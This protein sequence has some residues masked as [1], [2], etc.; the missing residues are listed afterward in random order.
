MPPG[1]IAPKLARFCCPDGMSRSSAIRWGEALRRELEAGRAPPQTRAARE[2]RA[3][4][5]AE[6]KEAEQRAAREAVTVASW[7]EE[8]LSDCEARRV[9]AT[10]I[11]LRRI[12]L[13]YLL[14]VAGDRRVADV[15]VLDLQ[16]LRRALSKLAPSSA[17]RYVKSA[18]TCLR[19]A[20]AA[21]LRGPL[22]A[23]EPIRGGAEDETPESFTLTELARLVAAAAVVSDRHLAVVLLGVDAGL[24]IGEIAGLRVEDIER[25]V[26]VVRRTIVRINRA[27][28]EH[29]PK[30]GRVRRIPATPRLLEVLQ[31][32]ADASPDGWLVRAQDGRP[33]GAHH[34]REAFKTVV[35]RAGMSPTNA[36]RLRHSFATHALE[37]G[38]TLEEVRRL[39]GHHSI[40]QTSRYLHSTEQSARAAIDRLAARHA[41]AG[42]CDR[43]V[44]AGEPRRPRLVTA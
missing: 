1:Q 42:E 28:A 40:Q 8:Y 39:L 17:Q 22:P 32:L 19:A 20:H 38:A 33:A 12:Q 35:R 21:G 10:T 41:A 23:L 18:A 5:D 31:R 13:R 9:R 14:D 25:G 2:Q 7:V 26:V 11:R 44:T 36:H 43:G 27:R 24:R 3:A 6:R 4:A 34:V 37:S 30:S 15:G 29:A 16:R